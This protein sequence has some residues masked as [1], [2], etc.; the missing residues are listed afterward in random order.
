MTTRLE[1]ILHKLAQEH[2]PALLQSRWGTDN[3]PVTRLQKMARKL[4]SYNIAVLVGEVPDELTGLKDMYV[5]DWTRTYGQV[6]SLLAQG[7]FPSFSQVEAFYA[8]DLLPAVIVLRGDAI[9]VIV[10][11][12]GYIMPY[13]AVR[14]GQGAVTDLELR[15]FM[16]IVL[17]ELE[18]GDLKRSK[19]EHIRETGVGLLR[20]LLKSSIRSISLTAFDKPILDTIQPPPPDIPSQESRKPTPPPDTLPEQEKLKDTLEDLPDGDASQTPTEQLFTN[21]IPL[22]K[23]KRRRPPIPDLPADDTPGKS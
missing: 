22:S 7:L 20:Q 2:A 19:Y 3:D 11:M 1:R 13:V 18:A 21:V 23:P 4:A 16:D 17:D 15:G 14:Q 6:Y 8:D 5:Q 10:V 9:P 12:A